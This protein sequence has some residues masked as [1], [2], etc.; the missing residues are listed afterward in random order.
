MLDGVGHQLGV[1][2]AGLCV[3]ADDPLREQLLRVDAAG[4]GG[5]LAVPDLLEVVPEEAV[6]LAHVADLG[7]ARIGAQDALRVGD[8]AHDLPGDDLGRREDVDGVAERLAHLPDAVRAEDDGRL[9]EDR[10]RLGERVAVA[11]C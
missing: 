1:A 8:H 9:G 11:A 6:E 4:P 7:A 10:L 5:S 2:L 3:V